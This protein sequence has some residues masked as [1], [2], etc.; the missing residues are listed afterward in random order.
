MKVVLPAK[1]GVIRRDP[2]LRKRIFR[3]RFLLTRKALEA[4][5]DGRWWKAKARWIVLGFDDPELTT[6]RRSSPAASVDAVRM[7]FMLCAQL[8]MEFTFADM[9]TTFMQA[10][11]RQRPAGNSTC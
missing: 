5:V 8:M 3:S 6:I 10:R 11:K 1:A 9:K 7:V 4:A 2:R